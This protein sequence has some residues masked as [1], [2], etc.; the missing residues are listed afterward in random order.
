MP[1][2]VETDGNGAAALIESG[3]QIRAQACHSRSI[4][5]VCG[6]GCQCCQALLSFRP[7]AGEEL[8]FGAVQLQREGE[9]V[10]AL[11]GVLRQQLFAGD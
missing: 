9:L 8:A 6:A 1:Q 4:H 5:C 11:P 3:V 2:V 10:P 7:R